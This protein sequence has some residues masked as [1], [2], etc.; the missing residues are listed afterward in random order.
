MKGLQALYAPGHEWDNP[1]W[2]VAITRQELLKIAPERDLKSFEV[3]IESIRHE[4]AN[5]YSVQ[6]FVDHLLNFLP[7]LAHVS[8]WGE[9]SEEFKSKLEREMTTVVTERIDKNQPLSGGAWVLTRP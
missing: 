4:Y 1:E 6:G 3:D 5:G 7:V 8:G 2:I 9:C